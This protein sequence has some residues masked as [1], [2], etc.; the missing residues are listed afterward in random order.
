MCAIVYGFGVLIHEAIVALPR[1]AEKSIPMAVDYA[2]KLN[3]E[4]PFTDVKGLK[5]EIFE[6]ASQTP[7][8]FTH[9]AH[10]T[11]RELV[12]LIVG[13]VVAIHIYKLLNRSE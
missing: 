5:S 9:V 11:T 8:L 7:H 6:L 13:I 1:I 4:L 3:V 2:S 10:L 12:Y